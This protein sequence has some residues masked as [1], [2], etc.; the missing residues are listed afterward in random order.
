MKTAMPYSF[1]G[2]DS[3]LL[4]QSYITR[5]NAL[6]RNPWVD[7]PDWVQA[8]PSQSLK[9]RRIVL[10]GSKMPG[11]LRFI[12]SHC[13]VIG[14][15]DDFLLRSQQESMGIP[16]LSTD[17]W[18]SMSRS[19]TEIVSIIAVASVAGDD[20]F[21]RVIVQYGL[22]GL[23][24]LEALRILGADTERVSGIG[25]TFVY[26]LPFFRHAVQHVDEHLR[27]AQ[28]LD[29]PYSRFTYFSILN[30]RLSADPRTLQQCAVG[31]NTHRAGYGSYIFNRSF[32]SFSEDEVFVDGGAFDGDSVEQFLSAV[33]GCFRKVYAFEP[34]PEIAQRCR[35]RIRSLQTNYLHELTSRIAVIERGL[36][37]KETSLLFNPT[38][39]APK[40][41]ALASQVPLAGHVIEA[42]MSQH[43]YAPEEESDGSFRIPTTS[44]DAVCDLPAS[45]IKLEVEGSEL[46]ALEGARNTIEHH[47]PKMAISVYHKP[48]DLITLLDFVAQTGKNYRMSLR[49]HNPHVPDAMVCYCY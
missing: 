15:V 4:R 38:Q 8:E 19:D 17:Q 1:Q 36:W 22:R 25:N 21:S 37:S 41:T 47:R 7:L 44:I 13:E 49:Q 46:K 2:F 40:E 28:L 3:E 18:I 35:D 48:E 34:S 31:Y 45:F 20:H 23:R 10:C 14:I 26:G 6:Q 32:F 42:G 9:G 33:K 5:A 39:Y 11:E 16:L 43:L 24:M 27:C 29:D 12:A 30:Y